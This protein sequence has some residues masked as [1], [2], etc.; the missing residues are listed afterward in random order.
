MTGV[1][2]QLV[3]G[4]PDSHF[5]ACCAL[6]PSLWVCLRMWCRDRLV[7]M[8]WVSWTNFCCLLPQPLS[9]LCAKSQVLP[10][11]RHIS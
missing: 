9:F 1:G 6:L 5:S 4:R 2:S 7:G 8:G 11:S 10:P 3:A